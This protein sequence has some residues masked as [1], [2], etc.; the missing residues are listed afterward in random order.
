LRV[1]VTFPRPDG[2]PGLT[3]TAAPLSPAS[4]QRF[5]PDPLAV[6]AAIYELDRRGFRLTRRGALSASFRV[7]R[8][9]YEKTFGTKLAA[10]TLDE[11]QDYAFRSFYFPP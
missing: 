5:V 4:V 6:D 7:D 1:A 8:A 11:A 9:I 2:G 10:L 3:K